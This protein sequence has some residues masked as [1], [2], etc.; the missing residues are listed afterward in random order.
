MEGEPM[1][2]NKQQIE[3]AQDRIAAFAALSNDDKCD[4]LDYREAELES[5][6]VV[7]KYELLDSEAAA[8]KIANNAYFSAQEIPTI[9]EFSSQA[10]K[11]L[12]DR[13]MTAKQ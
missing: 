1:V 10:E 6:S 3:A 5:L 8:E 9:D 11:D 12:H 4:A 7:E 13:I 2:P